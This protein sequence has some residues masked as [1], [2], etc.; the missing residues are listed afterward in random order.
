MTRQ[1]FPGAPGGPVLALQRRSVV[2]VM[3]SVTA[4][5]LSASCLGGQ[6]VPSDSVRGLLQGALR[7]TG[8]E[9]LQVTRRTLSAFPGVSFYVGRRHPPT[10][11]AGFEDPRPVQA[12]VVQAADWIG[13]IQSMG[14]IAVT[15][16][17]LRPQAVDSVAFRESVLSLLDLSGLI[18]EASILQGE[19]DARSRIDVKL[20][21]D[22]TALRAVV[23]PSVSAS[24]GGWCLVVFAY[25]PNGIFQYGIQLEGPGELRI[26]A[27]RV[28][29]Y[30]VRM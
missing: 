11:P 29:D 10:G 7:P 4:L 30:V 13:V 28:T 15:W 23:G 17:S 2:Q 25:Q 8:V 21:E 19:A 20:L 22:S 3:G 24:S 6:E 27:N 26:E 16:G 9:R 1:A 5:L 18:P 12:T 14:D